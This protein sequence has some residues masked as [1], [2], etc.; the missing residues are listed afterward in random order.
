MSY[1]K[2]QNNNVQNVYTRPKKDFTDCS[3]FLQQEQSALVG[4]VTQPV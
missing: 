4:Q 1:A 2:S 3:S